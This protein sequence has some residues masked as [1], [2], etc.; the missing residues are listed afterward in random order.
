[1]AGRVHLVSIVATAGI[2]LVVLELVRRRRLLERYAIL[3][4]GAA[5]IL[6]VLAVWDGLLTRLSHLVG[7]LYPPTA[8][9]AIA[10]GAILVLLMHFS[11]AV[12]RL[13]DQSKVLA[14][15]L[16]ML[17]E[18]LRRSEERQAAATGESERETEPSGALPR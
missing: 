12:S 3:W 10:L 18:R 8:L 13:T 1:M 11:L 7:I 6:L 4:L 16:A 9:F 5:L 17:E 2:L 14:Q 15:R